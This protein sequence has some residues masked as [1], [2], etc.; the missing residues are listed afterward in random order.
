MWYGAHSLVLVLALTLTLTLHPP[1][2]T[3]TLHLHP[4]PSPSAG[5]CLCLGEWE[6]FSAQCESEFTGIA[7][8]DGEE[9]CWTLIDSV[10]FA[11]RSSSPPTSPRPRRDLALTSL[12]GDALSVR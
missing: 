8:G 12:R 5:L 3:L 1:P 4:P 10:Y 11:V 9:G 7:Y 6:N 2:S